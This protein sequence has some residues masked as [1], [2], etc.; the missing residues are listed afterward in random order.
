M[1]KTILS[2]ALILGL[3]SSLFA[4]HNL[5]FRNAG[6]ITSGTLNPLRVS[7]S[8]FTLRGQLADYTQTLRLASMTVSGTITSTG[9]FVGDASRLTNITNAN[10]INN[11]SVV[12]S[13][14]IGNAAIRNTEIASNTITGTNI[15]N[16]S[17][18]KRGNLSGAISFGE[19]PSATGLLSVV[20][21]GQRNTASGDYSVVNGGQD[22][23]VDT[24]YTIIGGGSSNRA[25]ANYGVV[26]GGQNNT[27]NGG[28]STVGG[29]QDNNASSNH[30]TVPGGSQNTASG[31]YSFAAGRLS[32]S[33]ASGTFTWSDDRD[34]VINNQVTNQTMFSNAGGFWV[35]T[36]VMRNVAGFN[37][38]SS[39]LFGI[40]TTSPT[41]SLDVG[42][43]SVTV[44][45]AGLNIPTGIA[46]STGL[47]L[48]SLT[49][50]D[51][52]DTDASGN[53]ICGSDAT[54][55]GGGTSITT[56][57]YTLSSGG[58]VALSSIG[59]ISIP[60]AFTTVG[61]STWNVREVQ[62][63]NLV[64]STAGSSQYQIALSTVTAG[65]QVFR[66]ITPTVEV[67]TNNYYSVW[68]STA[69]RL[70]ADESISLHVT[71]S[72]APT[73]AALA[74]EYGM[75]LKF[76]REPD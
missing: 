68:T 49:G 28:R 52:V 67:S 60:G 62:A 41:S 40:R 17:V 18:T 69:F 57:T 36:S 22:N 16:S 73:G 47:R 31:G 39:N 76:W 55:G 65:N 75:K 13:S 25:D 7:P 38:N 29:G 59:F 14:H 12:L 27:A 34:G 24:S 56:F 51:T 26:S 30:S 35:S 5:I 71:F 32:S 66:Y 42:I 70:Q 10:S 20:G 6:D 61:K 72:S 33:T 43:G 58:D 4:I 45:G 19:T 21:G 9:G 46:V 1:K 2:L 53:L 54:G 48:T 3:Q 44:R 8:S 11:P 37:L 64:R 15:D 23:F 63:F 50:C 74:A